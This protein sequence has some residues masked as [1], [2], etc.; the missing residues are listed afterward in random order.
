MRVSTCSSALATILI[1]GWIDTVSA[2]WGTIRGQVTVSGI[3]ATPRA[4][5]KKGDA[6]AKDSAV[7]AAAE[8]P[9][10][11]LIVD[12]KSN[13]LANV[14]IYLTKK[15]ATIHP[16]LL[17]QPAEDVIIRQVGCRFVPH[18]TVLR[19]DQTLRIH[20]D[21]G[22]GHN[23]HLYP[24]KNRLDSVVQPAS[25]E[26]L[27]ITT[28]KEPERVPLRIDCDIHPWMRGWI[29]VQDH[30]YVAVTNAQGEFEIANLPLGE[31]DFSVWH[32]RTGYIQKSL[33]INVRQEAH[34]LDPIQIPAEKLTLTK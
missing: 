9:D 22:I 16:D 1:L 34:K 18:V 27:A 3:I 25:K 11:S 17:K 31:H 32:E 4:L 8:I 33:K 26:G 30:P 23:P 5:V 13:G 21:D 10:E 28:L 20:Y 12:P 19:T 24:L 29:V 2:Q 14:V 7:C 15:P 6:N